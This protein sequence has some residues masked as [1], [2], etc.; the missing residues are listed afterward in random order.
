VH[1]GHVDSEE[2]AHE[3]GAVPGLA[4]DVIPPH[5]NHLS[6]TRGRRRHG[7]HGTAPAAEQGCP[8]PSG[9]QA[10]DTLLCLPCR[11]TTTS[12]KPGDAS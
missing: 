11:F 7:V 3:R 6:A 12:I 5:F 2:V 1:L 9:E 4:D 8:S 10:R